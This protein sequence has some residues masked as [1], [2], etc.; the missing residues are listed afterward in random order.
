MREIKTEIVI[1]SSAETVWQI[2]MDFER[3]PEWNPLV[4][5]IS[6]EPRAGAKLQ[7]FVQT[8]GASA[9]NLAPTVL[10]AK[11]CKEFRW[12]G[13]LLF[14]GLFDGEHSCIIEAIS[15][16]KVR[17]INGEKFK[18]ILIPLFGGTLKGAEKGFKLMNEALKERAE[19]QHGA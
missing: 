1:E 10:V 2:L 12:L 17:F 14:G 13:K 15:E 5:S 9:M 8:P 11:E 19:K 6:G 18:G 7:M 16:N 4:K 3:Y